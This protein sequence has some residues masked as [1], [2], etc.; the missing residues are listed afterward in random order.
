M[1]H[2][3]TL[4]LYVTLC[5]TICD[6]YFVTLVTLNVIQFIGPSNYGQRHGIGHL[7]VMLGNP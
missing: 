5:D 7:L 2:P 3:V 1:I 6:T 4:T